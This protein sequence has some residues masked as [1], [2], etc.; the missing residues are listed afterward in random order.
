MPNFE[1]IPQIKTPKL[2]SFQSNLKAFTTPL[3]VFKHINTIKTLNGNMLK[4]K[5]KNIIY[6]EL[7]NHLTK[8]SKSS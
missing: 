5:Y 7:E 2:N 1:I 4:S 6:I 3:I 8:L